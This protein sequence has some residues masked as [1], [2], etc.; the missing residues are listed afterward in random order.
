[1]D[2]RLNNF[3][4]KRTIVCKAIACESRRLVHT[5]DAETHHVR[6]LSKRAV[7]RPVC[8]HT[9]QHSNHAVVDWSRRAT[10]RQ[11]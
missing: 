10:N 11:L 6:D 7:Q 8:E 5:H 1:M 2:N 4:R 9:S 3:P